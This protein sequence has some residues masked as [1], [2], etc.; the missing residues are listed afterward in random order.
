MSHLKC[1]IVH[2]LDLTWC[3]L[4]LAQRDRLRTMLQ[5][6]HAPHVQL[7]S[8]GHGGTGSFVG[9]QDGNTANRATVPP[10]AQQ[11]AEGIEFISACEYSCLSSYSS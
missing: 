7:P 11:A 2:S 8:L 9:Q 4:F 3:I 6:G 1:N 10:P 5:D